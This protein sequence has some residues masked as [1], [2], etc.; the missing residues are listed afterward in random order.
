MKCA[1]SYITHTIYVRDGKTATWNI[2]FEEHDK[3]HEIGGPILKLILEQIARFNGA[4]GKA[5]DALHEAA[6]AYEDNS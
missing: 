4:T 2:Q 6:N 3:V 5:I 1:T